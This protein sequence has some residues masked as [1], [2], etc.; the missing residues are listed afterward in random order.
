M[1]TD[2]NK[3]TYRVGQILFVPDTETNT[4]IPFQIVEEI[5]RRTLEGDSTSYRIKLGIDDEV[6]MLSAVTGDIYESLDTARQMLLAN[7]TKWVNHVIIKAEQVAAE[8]Y[9]G[10]IK[11]ENQPS[12]ESSSSINEENE[13][14]RG[15]T[16]NQ[17]NWY[18]DP[19]VTVGETEN[20]SDNPYNQSGE[21]FTVE[22]SPGV[23]AKASMKTSTS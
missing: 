18:G 11:N 8:R 4:I 22:V 23:F 1:M 14:H 19:E 7:A 17:N 10:Y 21:V 9:G 12:I 15:E 16:K 2:R 5:V 20:V 6:M 13:P 3:K